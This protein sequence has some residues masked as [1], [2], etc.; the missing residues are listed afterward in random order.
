[1]WRFHLDGN[2]V[3]EIVGEDVR[4][5]AGA[6]EAWLQ[7]V[8][9]PRGVTLSLETGWSS[10]SYGVRGAIMVIVLR[11]RLALPV[12]AMFRFGLTRL[13]IDRLRELAA[14]IP[15]DTALPVGT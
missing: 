2:V 3:A 6:R 9:P 8:T 4:L 12:D 15:S 10:P 14:R 7:L 11:G 1:V 13:S 5:S